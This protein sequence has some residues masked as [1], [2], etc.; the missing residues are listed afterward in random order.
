MSTSRNSRK[1][2]KG[3]PVPVASSACVLRII[4]PP[5]Y[6]GSPSRKP[7]M[8]KAACKA[9]LKNQTGR[10]VAMTLIAPPPPSLGAGAG[11]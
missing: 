4:S 11:S 10:S 5:Y 2:L 6:P 7:Q 3:G 1:V 9:A 8:L